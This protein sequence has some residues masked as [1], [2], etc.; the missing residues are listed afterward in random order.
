[1]P[2][3]KGEFAMRLAGVRLW[4]PALM[5]LVVCG[6]FVSSPASA[7]LALGAPF[8]IVEPALW[9]DYSS[10]WV[11]AVARNDGGRFVVIQSQGTGTLYGVAQYADIYDAQANLLQHVA[12]PAGMFEATMAAMDAQGNFV[13]AAQVSGD[14]QNSNPATAPD[15]QFKAQRFAADGTPVGS[16]IDIADTANFH[17]QPPDSRPVS[18]GHSYPVLSMDASGAF[19]LSWNQG[20]EFNDYQYGCAPMVLY[21]IQG[22]TSQYSVYARAFHAD[23]SA[24]SD[25][26][27]VYSTPNIT[28]HSSAYYFTRKGS[29]YGVTGVEMPGPVVAMSGADAFLVAF[30]V[31]TSTEHVYVERYSL[32]GKLQFKSTVATLPSHTPGYATYINSATTALGVDSRQNFIVGWMQPGAYVSSS[33]PYDA[34]GYWAQKYDST[35]KAVGTAKQI[36]DDTQFLETPVRL[37][38]ADSGDFLADWTIGNSPNRQAQQFASDLSAKSAAVTLGAD[39]SVNY[40]AA[41]GVLLAADGEGNGVAVWR[42]VQD[43]VQ[44]GLPQELIGV[45]GRLIAG[46]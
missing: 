46:Y 33:L 11:D 8:V 4:S 36:L 30:D 22:S 45:Q 37:T 5:G 39:D 23:G 13:L 19:V 32:N 18:Y 41:T 28:V 27:K 12:L 29:Y 34:A 31:P 21:C 40:V 9:A 35:G 42:S 20:A 26:V 38:L 1:M 6:V 24:A 7:D 43:L 16:V 2:H 3:K 17:Y 15:V 44:P 10:V 14:P 25:V